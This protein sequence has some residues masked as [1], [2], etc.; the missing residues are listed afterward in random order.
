MTWSWEKFA[1]L[2]GLIFI[3]STSWH[4]GRYVGQMMGRAAMRNI[5]RYIRK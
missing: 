4:F 1:I 3:G 2:W 5:R